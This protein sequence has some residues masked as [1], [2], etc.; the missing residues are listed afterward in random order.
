MRNRDSNIICMIFILLFALP[1]LGF[2]QEKTIKGTVVSAGDNLPL[3]GA[4]VIVKGTSN[5]F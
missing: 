3:P 4:T 1:S 2:G 5:G